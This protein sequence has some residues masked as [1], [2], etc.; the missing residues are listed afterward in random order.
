MNWVIRSSTGKRL[1]ENF[2]RKTSKACIEQNR[3]AIRQLRFYGI[4][5]T[6]TP[7]GA[8][9]RN[10]SKLSAE[11]DSGIDIIQLKMVTSESAPHSNNTLPSFNPKY[12]PHFH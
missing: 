12:A 2:D 6:D 9:F 10:G 3:K 7:E 11:K 4:L 1:W 5:Q 8:G